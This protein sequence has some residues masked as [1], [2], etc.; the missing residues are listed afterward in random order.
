MA[1][2][3]QAGKLLQCPSHFVAARQRSDAGRPGK[4]TVVLADRKPAI[5]APLAMHIQRT[6]ATQCKGSTR[7]PDPA[8][9]PEAQKILASPSRCVTA[10][11]TLTPNSCGLRGLKCA[12]LAL[13]LRSLSLPP[14]LPNRAEVPKRL[15][16]SARDMQE[17]LCAETC[18][19][20]NFAPN[21]SCA[22]NAHPHDPPNG[23]SEMKSNPR[24]FI[25]LFS[26]TNRQ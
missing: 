4:S 20:S 21:W 18:R 3:R 26:K 10:R 14:A 16:P 11:L 9:V 6:A 2:K 8:M 15:A 24:R 17:L 25:V 23:G 7:A 5:D 22:L 19:L 1:K 12:E 13:V